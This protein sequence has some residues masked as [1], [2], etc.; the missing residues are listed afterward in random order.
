M[1]DAGAQMDE[2]VAKLKAAKDCTRFSRMPSGLAWHCSVDL[3][4]PIVVGDVEGV[5]NEGLVLAWGRVCRQLEM[6]YAGPLLA[7][8]WVAKQ[9]I[10]DTHQR[11]WTPTRK[12][13]QR[14]WTEI[15]D[16]HTKEIADTHQ[17]IERDRERL[18]TPTR[19]KRSRTPTIPRRSNVLR[20]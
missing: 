7:P 17:E 16:T 14:L 4:P 9:E 8:N 1:A 2:R 13:S 10:V 5:E 15:V 19:K 11:L 18:W 6:T 3:K 12:R 20:C